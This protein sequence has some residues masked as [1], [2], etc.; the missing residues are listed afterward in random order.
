MKTASFLLLLKEVAFGSVVEEG[1]NSVL[2][3]VLHTVFPPPQVIRESL[4]EVLDSSTVKVLN[5]FK[6]ATFQKSI[7][8]H[9]AGL[10]LRSQDKRNL[11][12]V[13]SRFL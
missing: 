6:S 2:F 7:K 11:F 1:C 12:D 8:K 3:Q 10:K 4:L 5:P 13:F 9:I